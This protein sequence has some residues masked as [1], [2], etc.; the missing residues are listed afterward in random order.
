MIISTAEEMN[1]R[2][3]STMEDV[4]VVHEEGSWGCNDDKMTFVGVYD[5]HG[6]RGI[7]E[8]L[9][10]NMADNIARELN[11]TEPV[12][13][14]DNDDKENNATT[15]NILD[16]QHLSKKLKV[17][18]DNATINQRLERAF[19]ITDIQS[20]SMDILTSGATV[21]ICLIKVS[22]EEDTTV[23][24]S[25]HTFSCNS[26]QKLTTA[27]SLQKFPCLEKSNEWYRDNSCG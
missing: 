24:L 1:P 7:V 15:T 16:T 25:F 20:R 14:D 19:L 6:G 12:H 8:F 21:V 18:E 23:K 2:K 3:R 10:D 11:H 17:E 13:C 26:S 5:G 4:H 9:E 27:T 22:E